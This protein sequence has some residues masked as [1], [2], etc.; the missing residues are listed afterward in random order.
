MTA[1]A[2]EDIWYDW[3]AVVMFSH[4]TTRIMRTSKYWVNDNTTTCFWKSNLLSSDF[5]GTSYGV[6][7]ILY[8]SLWLVC[9]W[10]QFDRLEDGDG[11]LGKDPPESG[12]EAEDL[13]FLW[14]RF[15]LL[16]QHAIA[17]WH[18]YHVVLV[19]LILQSDGTGSWFRSWNHEATF[20]SSL[21]R[22]V[23][24]GRHRDALF[25]SYHNPAI[26][27]RNSVKLGRS[28]GSATGNGESGNKLLVHVHW[29]GIAGL[30][31]R[32]LL[33]F[34][35]DNLEKSWIPYIQSI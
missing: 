16:K 31:F 26:M 12:A 1:A 24:K 10:T 17:T 5:Q 3:L 30:H 6:G 13:L 19:R 32:I 15:N 22:A 28:H 27:S 29:G 25:L 18:F 21:A 34:N 35:N 9:R 8:V 33:F 4:H 2:T 20:V 14:L 11:V 23:F 7:F